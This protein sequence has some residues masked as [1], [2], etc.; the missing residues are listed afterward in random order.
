MDE[1]RPV[2]SED[3]SWLRPAL[4]GV[5]EVQDVTGLASGKAMRIRGRRCARRTICAPGA[6]R[7]RARQDLLLRR[8]LIKM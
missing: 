6:A 8:Q 2:P 5:F 4:A 7:R 3:L 1:I